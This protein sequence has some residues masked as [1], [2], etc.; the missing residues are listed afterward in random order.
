[1]FA[2]GIEMNSTWHSKKGKFNWNTF[3]WDT[4]ARTKAIFKWNNQYWY[5]WDVSETWRLASSQFAYFSDPNNGYINDEVLTITSKDEIETAA[6][7]WEIQAGDLL[8]TARSDG[9]DPH[10]AMMVTKVENGE[11]YFAAHTNNRLDK[12]LSEVIGNEQV[13]VI[14]IRDEAG[15]RQ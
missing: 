15:S 10:H 5:D 3:F 2:G 13:K 1:L 9:T 12:P 11:I 4:G 7:E 8:Y 14:R 6:N